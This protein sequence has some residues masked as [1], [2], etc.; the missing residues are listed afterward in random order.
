M[1]ASIIGVVLSALISLPTLAKDDLGKK[2]KVT[3]GE[4]LAMEMNG[5]VDDFMKMGDW[6]APVLIGYNVTISPG[7]DNTYYR[8]C[9]DPD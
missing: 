7:V 6:K 9:S 1:K 3:L 8:C 2:Y 4:L 5:L